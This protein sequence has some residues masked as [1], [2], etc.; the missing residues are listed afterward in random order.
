MAGRRPHLVK[1][2]VERAG[3]GAALADAAIGAAL[4]ELAPRDVLVRRW[5]RDH[6]GEPP[7]ALLAA[8]DALVAEVEAA[9]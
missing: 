7:L 5:R 8:F 6:E 2:A 1:I 9:R 3:D 4:A